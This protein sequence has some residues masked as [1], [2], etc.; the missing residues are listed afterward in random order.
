MDWAAF[1][2]DPAHKRLR[3]LERI[4]RRRFFDDN[5]ADQSLEYALAK[6]KENEWARLN[7][8][9]HKASADTFLIVVYRR[10]IED[11]AI[12]QFGKCRAPV[13]VQQLGSLWQL[14]YKRLCCERQAIDIVSHKL[15]SSEISADSVRN[16]CVRIKAKIPD[17]GARMQFESLSSAALE[18]DDLA[19]ADP[20]T[21]SP[22]QEL[23]QS[24]WQILLEILGVSLASPVGSSA[25]VYTTLQTELN[26]VLDANTRLLLKMVFQ[27]D[28]SMAKSALILGMPEHTAR[29]QIKSVLDHWRKILTRAGFNYHG[30]L[31][32]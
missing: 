4:A 11:F 16:M 9:Q 29:R 24:Q 31:D 17:C 2:F 18:V 20:N 25:S 13:W 7:T 27:D 12:S 5:L 23:E 21:L 32:E 22:E 30:N 19:I 15:S 28:L 3:R 6:L 1:L 10:L 26:Q 14:V 8:F